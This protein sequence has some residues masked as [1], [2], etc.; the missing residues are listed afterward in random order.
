M[1]ESINSSASIDR[2]RR[3]LTLLFSDLSESTSLGEQMDAEE[4]ADLL[5][6]LRSLSQKVIHR[7]GGQIARIQG[8]GVLA[9]FGYPQAR[10]DDG[11][12]ATE[13]ALELHAQ[14]SALAFRRADGAAL[15]LH[16][17][18]HAGLVF[19][20]D[21]DVERGRFELLGSVPNIAARLSSVAQANEVLVSEETL[22]PQVSYFR[23]SAPFLVQVKGRTADLE[24]YR[25]LE[26]VSMR[27][28][29]QAI[30]WRALSPFVGRE[31]PLRQLMTHLSNPTSDLTQYLVLHAGPGMGKT[32]LI[33][34][35]LTHPAAAS[36]RVLRGYCESYLSVEP[37]QPFVQMLRAAQPDCDTDAELAA[38]RERAVHGDLVALRAFFETLAAQRPLLLV[39]DD[40]Q[41]ADDASQQALDVV[42]TLKRQI[43]VVLASRSLPEGVAT[44]PVAVVELQPL[45]EL[46]AAKAVQNLVRDV[47]PFLVT[48]IRRY[49]GGIP[50]FIEELC[51]SAA[52][53]GTLGLAGLRPGGRAWL[54]G[55]IESRLERLPDE[56]AAL[57]RAAAVMGNAFPVW[58]FER[59]TGHGLSSPSLL[60]LAVQDFVFPGEQPDTLR[61]KHGITRD[62]I[63]EAIGL[64]ERKALHR[65]IASALLAQAELG[66]ADELLEAL[67]YHFSA[68]GVPQDAA[69]YAELAGDKAMAASALD[70]ARAQ[71]SAALKALDASAPLDHDKRLRWCAI[72]QKLGM[73]CVFDPLALAEGLEIFE[74]GVLFARAGGDR[75]ILARAEYWLGYLF[76][77]KG[78]WRPAVEH[79]EAALRLATELQDTR[80]AAQIRAT[81]GQ[82]LLSACHYDRALGLLDSALDGKRRQ[83]QPGGNIAV[84][85]AYTLACKGYLLAD[86]GQFDSADECFAQALHL[87][88]DVR[89]QVSASVRHWIS[90]ARQWQGRWEEAVYVA[91]D[92]ADIAEHVKSRQQLAMARALAGRARWIL[93]ADP[94]ALQTVREASAWIESRKGELATSLTHGW[95]V[96][97]ELAEGHVKEAR[98]HAARL[99]L[100]ARRDD[101]IGEALGC[102]ALA[103]AAMRAGNFGRAEHYLRRAQL[104]AQARG[105]AHEH[106]SNTLCQAQIALGHGRIDDAQRLLDRAGTAFANLRMQWH[107]EQVDRMRPRL[108]TLAL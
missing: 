73:A 67:A 4:Y 12:R 84:G 15:S 64:H 55:L 97:G 102:R 90:V 50:L 25:V 37:L 41:W 76:Y 85:S 18:I 47:D 23:T 3:Y 82:A 45:D 17:G 58:L 51:H 16:S 24:V 9:L 49:A 20:S 105:S 32:R 39:I 22:G 5:A 93:S 87:L 35:F 56:Q 65:R 95:L 57:V 60:A 61:F 101:R 27:N 99:L 104:S 68:G 106:A 36:Y 107:L 44:A 96:E 83:A 74:R 92:A 54:N 1:V 43:R 38:L 30:S 21:G 71:F 29:S 14:V 78:R 98:K 91:Q 48:E 77:A 81:L 72:A 94:H 80:L 53:H 86:R 88:G 8:D 40:W 69:H 19:L 79:C 52:V 34:E 2:H 11:R 31:E 103:L 6:V 89:H 7:H 108:L 42:L 46:T 100:R 70:R 10:E 26:R 62:V 59:I 75:K 28:R 63:Y 33:E 66:T 13:A